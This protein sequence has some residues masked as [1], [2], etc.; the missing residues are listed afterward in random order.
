MLKG[1]SLFA[2]RFAS[3]S[4]SYIVIG[5]TA[6]YLNLQEQGL[7]FRATKDID[8]VLTVEALTPAFFTVFLNFVRDGGYEIHQKA[9]G[10]PVYYRFAKPTNQEFPSILELFSRTPPSFDF[11]PGGHIIPL[12]A[13]DEASSL[14]AILLDESYYSYLHGGSIIIQGIRVAKPESLIPLKAKAWLDL[15]ERKARGEPVDSRNIAKHLKDIPVL[16]GIL[17]PGECQPLPKNIESDILAF[18]DAV[19]AEEDSLT[20]IDE[21]IREFYAL[22]KKEP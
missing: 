8:I 9:D 2:K 19:A 7:E 17:A 16:F 10:Q 15:R 11:V 1:L 13:G 12:P 22:K 14:S 3:F 21:E 6:C 5:G 18:L 20:S 4:D